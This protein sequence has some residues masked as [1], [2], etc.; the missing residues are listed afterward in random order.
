MISKKFQK[1]RKRHR[2]QRRLK[3]LQ[4]CS[5]LDDFSYVCH[6]IADT[7]PTPY[8]DAPP[9]KTL[10]GAVWRRG[11]RRAGHC[12]LPECGWW[13]GGGW[14]CSYPCAGGGSME[15]L[16]SNRV[17]DTHIRH[18]KCCHPN[19]QGYLRRSCRKSPLTFL[20]VNAFKGLSYFKFGA[21]T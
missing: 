9:P 18:I 16:T 8:P 11:P 7:S 17:W 20:M 6:K 15:Q 10:A 2:E 12:R 5:E 13:R 3:K 21:R 1:F 4:I 14:R 19:A